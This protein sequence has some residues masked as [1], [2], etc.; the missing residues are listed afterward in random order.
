MVGTDILLTAITKKGKRTNSKSLMHW[1]GTNP[2]I[3]CSLIRPLFSTW[4]L[5]G[6]TSPMCQNAKIAFAPFPPPTFHLA[7]RQ[8]PP[9]TKAKLELSSAGIEGMMCEGGEDQSQTYAYS[10]TPEPL[11]RFVDSM[12]TLRLNPVMGPLLISTARRRILELAFSSSL[13]YISHGPWKWW[14][15]WKKKRKDWQI[16]K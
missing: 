14:Q 8:P 1:G 3:L 9:P 15:L 16:I 13:L 4:M 11:S 7:S 5:K 6:E 2:I 10:Y 12:S